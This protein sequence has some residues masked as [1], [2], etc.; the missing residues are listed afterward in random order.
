[1]R[2]VANFII[3]AMLA[4]VGVALALM[5]LYALSR[6]SVFLFLGR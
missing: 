6:T 5:S 2:R 4:S 3:T 1:M